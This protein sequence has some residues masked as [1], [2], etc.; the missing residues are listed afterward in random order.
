MTFQDLQDVYKRQGCIQR[1]VIIDLV[2][3][4]VAS[5][6]GPGAGGNDG[7][8]FAVGVSQHVGGKKFRH[9]ANVFFNSL[10]QLFL[11]DF[12][13]AEVGIAFIRDGLD[14]DLGETGEQIVQ[15][16]VAAF[17]WNESQPCLLYTS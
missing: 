16:I 7:E 4:L 13:Q 3:N 5:R 8:V 10:V 17:L 12:Q 14:A 15:S 11:V 9:V 6:L 1:A 2:F